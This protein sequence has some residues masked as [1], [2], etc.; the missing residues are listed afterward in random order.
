MSDKIAVHV[1]L[2]APAGKGDELV[3][4]F[5]ELYPGPLDAEPGT[6]LHVIHQAKDD[7]DTIFFYEVY[8]DDAAY[9]AHS[10]GEGLKAVLP[11]LAGLVAAPPEMV[12]GH[13]RNAKGLRL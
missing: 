10:Q 8:T 9:Q 3:A 5:N 2:T 11:K 4:A 1:K 13:P 7:P 12:V 6:E